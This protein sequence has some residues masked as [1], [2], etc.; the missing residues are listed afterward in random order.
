MPAPRPAAEPIDITP[1]SIAAGL[2]MIAVLCVLA[3]VACARA[4]GWL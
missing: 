3:V 4:Y 1:V 2:G